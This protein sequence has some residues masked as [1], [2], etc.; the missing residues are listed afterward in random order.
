MANKMMLLSKNMFFMRE[1][2]ITAFIATVILFGS[3]SFSFTGREEATPL[4]RGYKDWYKT[5]GD[6][7]I[8]GDD[9]RFLGGMHRGEAGYR[10][11]YINGIGESVNRG[12]KPY[13]YPEGTVVVKEQYKNKKDY[14]AGKNAALNVMVKLKEGSSPPTNDWGF[15]SA[16]NKRK[17]HSGRSKNAIFCGG[18]H[19][20][21]NLRSYDYIFVNSTSF[22]V[23]K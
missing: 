19:A 5:T 2:L 14:D 1:I 15:M 18:C 6:M 21:A 8:T 17:I 4:W 22:P 16:L 9:T 20:G 7:A 10:V 11:V 23:N 13:R 12:G 3:S